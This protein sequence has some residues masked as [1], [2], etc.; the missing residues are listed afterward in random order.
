MKP[1]LLFVAQNQLLEYTLK[2]VYYIIS[3]IDLGIFFE[4]VLSDSEV[5]VRVKLH[6]KGSNRNIIKK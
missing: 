1:W 6:K 4:K 2:F 3:M 5:F